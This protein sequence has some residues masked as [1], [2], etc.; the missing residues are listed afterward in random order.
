MSDVTLQVDSSR[1]W[2]NNRRADHHGAAFGDFDGDGDDD[3]YVITNSCCYSDLMVSDGTYFKN[4]AASRGLPELEGTSTGWTDINNDGD[5]DLSANGESAFT[6]NGSGLFT[7][8]R[9]FSACE[10]LDFIMHTDSTG[11]GRPELICGREGKFPAAAYDV[12][13]GSPVDVTSS[14]PVIPNIID[15]VA[16]D[17]NNDLRADIFALRGIALPNEATLVS[18]TRIEA[19]LDA[20]PAQGEGTVKFRGGGV[21]TMTVFARTPAVEFRT[22][23]GAAATRGDQITLDPNDP[24][25]V[26]LPS[27]RNFNGYFISYS[28]ANNEWTVVQSG[29]A[30]WWYTY[31]VIESQTAM[32]SVTFDGQRSFERPI[33]PFLYRST[34]NGYSNQTANAGLGLGLRCVSAGATAVDSSPRSQAPVERRDQ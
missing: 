28:P 33:T 13:S 6:S 30:G 12:S 20:S 23:S 7:G 19:A 5:L 10:E 26:G 14:L 2:L 18:P 15:A 3:L 25:V 11:D 29:A 4:E 24:A 31:V 32:S 8:T 34:G 21:L 17:F 1:S 16:A 22:G 9:Q 27:G